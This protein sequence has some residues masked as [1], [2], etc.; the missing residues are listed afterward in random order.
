MRI[1]LVILAGTL[2]TTAAVSQES[3]RPDHAERARPTLD[4][5]YARDD[6]KWDGRPWLLSGSIDN[7]RFLFY[8][9]NM[10]DEPKSGTFP[11]NESSIAVNPVD[12]RYLVSSAVDARTGAFVYVSSD[13]GVS[14]INKDLGV[15]RPNW[16][17]GNDPSVGWDYKGN[18]YLMYGAFPP[19]TA[20]Q[21][22][23][24]GIYVAKSTDNGV[25][26]RAHIPVI[27]HVGTMTA[28]SAFGDKYYI[29]IDN[30]ASSPYRGYMYTPWKR[31][32]DR[33]SSTQ[34]VISRSTDE[35]L[36][37]SIPV[38]VS[39]R[40]SGTST[41]TTFGQSFPLMSTGPDGTVYVV[42]NDGPA[43]SIG[44]AL[45]SDAGMTWT[46]PKYVVE[47]YQTQGTPRKSGND[48]Y[49]VLKE[50]FRAETY[51]TLA[52]DCSPSR[53][54]GTLYLSW[55]AGTNPDVFLKKST[56]HGA[57]WSLAKVVHSVLR[58]DQW[59]P[60]ISVDQT[61]GDVAVMYSDSR[62]DSANIAIDQYISY[63]SDGGETWVDRRATDMQSDFRNNP[64]ANR[65]FAGDYSGNA[66][67]DGRI[68]PSFL[69]TRADNDVYTALI[70]IHQPKPVENLKVGSQLGSHDS[71]RLAWTY[72]DSA[73]S[74]YETSLDSI[75]FVVYRDGAPRASL[76]SETRFFEDTG[77]NQDSTY[78][79]TVV[80]ATDRDTS[81]AR[82]VTYAPV[83]LALPLSP[84]IVRY[85][86]FSSE[87]SLDIRLP[88]LRGDSVSP[89]EN[90]ATLTIYEDAEVVE[91]RPL[92][93]SD[94]G[95]IVQVRRKPTV[96]A[97]RRYWATVSDAAASANTSLHSDTVVVFGGPLTPFT[98]SFD[99][100]EPRFLSDPTWGPTS[101][102][103]FSGSTSWTDSPDR[104]YRPRTHS[105]SVIW[106]VAVQGAITLGFNTIAI[107]D[108]G[109]SALVEVSY[110]ST[111]TWSVV[112]RYAVSDHSQWGDRRADP[113]DWVSVRI[114]LASPGANGLVLV[115]F[116]MQTGSLNN[117]DGWYID[118]IEFGYPSSI[119]AER[120]L[121]EAPRIVSWP[122][123]T[124]N[125]VMFTTSGIPAGN[126]SLAICDVL[127]R[128]LAHVE[129]IVA[130]D[131]R[132][133]QSVDVSRLGPGIYFVR[134]DCLG[135]MAWSRIVIRR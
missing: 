101:A 40:K 60:W 14:W 94:T 92:D 109:D 49:H 9:R 35:G 98:E 113:G 100:G 55:A 114:P 38:P 1:P 133:T 93:R 61:T 129:C 81:V 2:V 115:R 72:Y 17:S 71:A 41:D 110:D 24:S 117:I 39:P 111:A 59:W 51:P 73:R 119:A 131:G 64:Y 126:A 27:E 45:S 58:G 125:S 75:S 53:F 135:H 13:G 90:L 97:Y 8:N 57:T 33:D 80:V 118:D 25:T 47:G 134:I 85:D 32:V 128:D 16:I 107:V 67:H 15:V 52:V 82:S 48:V 21:G 74:V 103:S 34:I 105:S 6:A 116:R 18:A 77:L 5:D 29:Q 3:N 56:D 43:R 84:T 88:S 79:Y 42:W 76:N 30:A 89:L 122:N 37:W 19:F 28:D 20:G 26:W 31:V 112:A 96:R 7:S 86:R 23:Q 62:A 87:P 121:S 22:G 127:G 54:A 69:D 124:C 102:V 91:V 99:L 11:Q 70:S 12:P 36:T 120:S 123:P 63:S 108:P 65:I 68:Y 46:A 130:S 132:I 106:P 78:R 44:F 66:F 10:I 95:A 50:T 4:P 104:D 83:A